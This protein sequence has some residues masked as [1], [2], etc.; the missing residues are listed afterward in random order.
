MKLTVST[1]A[2][3]FI[4][5]SPADF[6]HFIQKTADMTLRKSLIFK[7]P[8]CWLHGFIVIK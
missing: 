4:Y 7:H 6:C 3:I 5:R 8:T 1:G 2:N